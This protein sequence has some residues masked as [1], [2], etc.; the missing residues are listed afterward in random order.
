MKKIYL[1]II[2][3]IF[4]INFSYAQWTAGPGN[5]Y[6]TN[7]GNVG[8]G[9]NSPAG[10]LTLGGNVSAPSWNNNGIN[11]QT[12]AASYTDSSTPASGSVYYNMVNSFG[13][14]TLAATNTAVTYSNAA[15]VYIAGVPVAGTNA[16]IQNKYSLFTNG[17]IG[18]L[19][20][21]LVYL[22]TGN[23]IY[24]SRN[25]MGPKSGLT[26]DAGT[27]IRVGDDA[28]WAGVLIAPK[29]GY[30]G[31]GTTTPSVKLDVAGSINMSNG[32]NL[33]WGGTFGANTPAIAGTGGTGMIF[34]PN[35]STSGEAMRISAA[36]N[37]GIGTT[38]TKG[39]KLA[40]N[41]SAIATSVTVKLYG[42]WPDYVFKPKYHLPNLSDV[43]TYI[44]QNH[45]LPD[46]PSETEVTKNGINLGE[47]NA[48]LLKKVEE[49][50]LYAIEQQ[51]QIEQ[52]NQKYEARIVTLEKA[53]SKITNNYSR[54]MKKTKRLKN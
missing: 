32:Y 53:L 27:Y 48:R 47:M 28:N 50:T 15:T 31:V 43:N 51:K 1:S 21:N 8:I 37:M 44:N 26:S 5:I 49:L 24:L 39:Y 30:V 17:D 25:G 10:L 35:G 52:L 54:Y 20:G 42:N 41:G 12:L 7:G 38:D 19:L 36:G 3:S 13:I 34:Y 2:A 16:T 22:N 11:L 33:T 4:V 14:P 6:N 29:G 23:G 9:T 45:H 40:V 18:I 46:M